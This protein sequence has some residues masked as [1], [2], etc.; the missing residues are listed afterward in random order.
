MS[1]TMSSSVAPSVSAAR[2]S[3]T[4]ISVRWLPCGKPMVVPTLTS[5]PT[6][7][8][9]AIGKLSGLSAAQRG[10]NVLLWQDRDLGYALVSD[11]DPK[12]LARL[13]Q[14]LTER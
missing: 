9:R 10:Y 13:A 5:V 3:A 6:R 11:M 12:A 14:K 7:T 8:D 4:L 2:A 1:S